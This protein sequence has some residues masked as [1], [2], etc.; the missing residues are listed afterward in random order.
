MALIVQK[1]G[2]TS[3][4][5]V[6]HLKKVADMVADRKSKGDS[7]VVVLSAMAGETNAL[8]KL[9]KEACAKPDERELDM[10]LSSGER[11]TIPLL[12]MVLKS[13]GINAISL[14]GRQSG[15]F[16]DGMHTKAR[17]K[18]IDTKNIA[19]WL[20]RDYVVVVAGFQGYSEEA[21]TVTTLGRGG[22][23][24]TGVALAVA[25]KAEHCEIC[26]DVD[27]VYT[28]D[29]RIVPEAK[30]INKVSYEEMLEM[31]SLGAKVLQTRSVEFAAKYD[32]PILVRSSF[33]DG[34]GTWVI[35]EDSSMEEVLVAGVVFSKDQ[36]KITITGVPDKPGCAASIFSAMAEKEI[37][38]DMIIQNVGA[39][40]LTDMSLTVPGDEADKAVEALAV[41]VKEINAKDVERR[42]DV[43]KISIVGVGMRSHTGVA[44]RMFSILADAGINIQMISTSEIKVS[45]VIGKEEIDSAVKLLHEGFGLDKEEKKG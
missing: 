7:L 4:A 32:M 38:V 11:V 22:S 8:L 23:D 9:A 30:R 43:G 13:R 15:I 2:G 16:T 39:G 14:T 3:V 18:N 33:K 12:A 19:K 29:P 35:K 41:K 10:L 44:A 5:D 42:D 36:S 31:A 25:L 28:T 17:I 26:T 1:Y 6:D 24:T 37:N 20:E 45:C 21:D 34:P 40:G 27:G